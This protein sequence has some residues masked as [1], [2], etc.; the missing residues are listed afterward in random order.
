MVAVQIEKMITY[1]EISKAIGISPESTQKLLSRRGVK[2][3]DALA[4]AK[5]II[6]YYLKK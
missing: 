5:L 3:N 1:K 2:T 6:K 4:V